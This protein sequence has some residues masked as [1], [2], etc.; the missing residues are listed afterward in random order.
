MAIRKRFGLA[1][2]LSLVA[3]AACS[4]SG[5]TQV[6]PPVVL[7]MLETAPPT[8]DDGQMQIYET[9]LP[10]PLPLR[11][12]ADNEVPK[13]AADPYPHPPF[14][15]ASDTRITARFTL[16]NLEDKPHTVE[17]LLDPWN[18]FVR[19]SPGV[20]V[21]EEATTPNFSGIDRF[22]IIPAKGRVEGIL[23]PDDIVEMATDLGT[24]ME[25]QKRPPPADGSFAGPALYNRAF[26]VQNRSSQP[27]PLLTP[28]VPKVV[29]GIVGF[30]LGLRTYEPAKLAVEVV[31]D[32]E[33]LN[34]DRV[35][36]AGDDTRRVGRP[37]TVLSPPPPP[38]MP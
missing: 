8:Y 4:N 12:P 14:D 37:G 26:N 38:M 17:L 7:G 31:L 13:G 3:V 33:D 28:Y 24:A 34:G 19:Y 20:I 2:V 32:V 25:L 16:S 29:A 35:I 27:D 21:G 9:Y 18:E 6:I 23:T 1:L 22:F 30:D 10:V 15:L 11:K 5:Q 36:P